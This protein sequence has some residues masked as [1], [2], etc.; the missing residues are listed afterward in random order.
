MEISAT[1]NNLLLSATK[2]IT[3]SQLVE[4]DSGHLL[5]NHKVPK[6]LSVVPKNMNK[7]VH[8][9]AIKNR[10]VNNAT[11]DPNQYVR[12]IDYN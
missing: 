5:V 4:G 3:S 9:E 11:E 2:E 8:F 1:Q 10:E 6:Q 12:H 7:I